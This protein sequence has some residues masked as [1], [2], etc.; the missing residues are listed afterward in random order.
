MHTDKKNVCIFAR[1]IPGVLSLLGLQISSNALFASYVPDNFAEKFSYFTRL[2]AD[3]A[4]IGLILYDCYL[5]Y[6]SDY[7]PCCLEFLSLA[8]TR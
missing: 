5:G 6:G 2:V 8:Q 4:Y 7:F 3:F 1:C